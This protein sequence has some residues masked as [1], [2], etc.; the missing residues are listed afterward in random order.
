MGV[1]T[2]WNVPTPAS[3]HVVRGVSRHSLAGVGVLRAR[4]QGQASWPGGILGEGR[5]LWGS[6]SRSA[7]QVELSQGP[8]SSSQVQSPRAACF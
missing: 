5:G 4:P 1:R 2:S 6:S 8:G 7:S 3:V